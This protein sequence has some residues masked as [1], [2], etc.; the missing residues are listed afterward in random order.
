MPIENNMLSGKV[1]ASR[2]PALTNPNETSLPLS[3]PKCANKLH[4]VN[5]GGVH[6]KYCGNCGFVDTAK[7][8]PDDMVHDAY[9]IIHNGK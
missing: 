6:M 1:A 9:P 8:I 2:K 3:C 7:P 5:S 4:D